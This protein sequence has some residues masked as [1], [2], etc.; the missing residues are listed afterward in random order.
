MWGWK[1]STGKKKGSEDWPFPLVQGT[2]E[3]QEDGHRQSEAGGQ[4]GSHL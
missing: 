2:W 3:A 1:W 4:A